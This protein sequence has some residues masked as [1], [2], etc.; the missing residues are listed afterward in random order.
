MNMT[1]EDNMTFGT[2]LLGLGAVILA[3]WLLK[4]VLVAMLNIAESVII[5]GFYAV[6]IYIAVALLLS[7]YASLNPKK[8]PRLVKAALSVHHAIA[9]SVKLFFRML[10]SFFKKKKSRS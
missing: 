7:I 5:V 8:T 1:K 4:A 2:L 9:Q 6:L 3:I 10:G